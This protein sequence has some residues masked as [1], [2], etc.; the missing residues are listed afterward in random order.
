MDFIR[1]LGI[2]IFITIIII[3]ITEMAKTFMRLIENSGEKYLFNFWPEEGTKERKNVEVDADDHLCMAIMYVLTLHHIL[4][5]A[6]G[7]GIDDSDHR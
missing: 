2:I 1:G 3:I 6:S 4:R 5:L 7:G